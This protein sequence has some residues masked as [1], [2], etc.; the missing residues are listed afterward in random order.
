MRVR[1]WNRPRLFVAILATLLLASLM[2]LAGCSGGGDEAT[3]ADFS[4][5]A[6]VQTARFDP[7]KAT[8]Q[9]GAKIDTSSVNEGYVAAKST[10]QGK[11]KLQIICGDASQNY[12]L[13]SNGTELIAPLPFGEG[14]YTFRIMKNTSGNNYVELYRTQKDVSIDDEFSPFVR[15]NTFCQFSDKSSCV[16]QAKS[17]VKDAKNEGEALKAVCTWIVENIDYDNEKAEKLKDATG[18]VPDPDTTLK[19][20]KGICF[21]YASLGAA[22]L[23][24]QGIPTKIRTGYVSPDNIYHAWIEVNIDGTWKSAQFS[25]DKRTWS[26]VDLTFAAGS[27]NSLV[28][29]GKDYTDRY[30][31]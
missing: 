12:D 15:P 30:T 7:S 28:G 21:D 18:Y 3:G 11:L 27:G 19:S 10:A 1:Q 31:Y 24:S 6:H 25:V 13:P 2:C 9:N 14:S 17:L 4:S 16:K 5:P 26:R 20:K 29:D 23:R 22:M 8:G